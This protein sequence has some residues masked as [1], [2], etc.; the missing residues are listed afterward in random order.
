VGVLDRVQADLSRIGSLDA[1]D[2]VGVARFVTAFNL[3]YGIGN[4]ICFR[5]WQCSLN[6][7]DGG[8]QG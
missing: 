3:E 4:S 8:E 5:G 1:E 6:A 7:A 2:S